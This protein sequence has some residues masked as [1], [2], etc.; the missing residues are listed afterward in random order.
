[1]TNV[2]DAVPAVVIVPAKVYVTSM[3]VI[4][5]PCRVSGPLYEWENLWSEPIAFAPFEIIVHDHVV[6][7]VHATCSAAL[8]FVTEPPPAATSNETGLPAEAFP[9]E[10]P[11]TVE[12]LL[13]E[14]VIAE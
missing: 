1:M 10:C 12:M 3:F 7:F 2:P 8:S 9:R 5:L 4:E 11:Y 6:P 14:D 13:A